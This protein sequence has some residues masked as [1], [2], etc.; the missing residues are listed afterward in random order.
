VPET[1][2]RALRSRFTPEYP[3]KTETQW[4]KSA[5]FAGFSADLGLKFWGD[6]I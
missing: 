2:A 5:V 4:V 3:R 6:S 1:T